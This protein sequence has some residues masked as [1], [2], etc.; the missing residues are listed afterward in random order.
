MDEHRQ[1]IA[2]VAMYATSPVDVAQYNLVMAKYETVLGPKSQSLRGQCFH[3]LLKYVAGMICFSCN[4]TWFRYVELGDDFSDPD[5]FKE[6]LRVRVSPTV[7]MDL[8][9]ACRPFSHAVMSL[10][11][12]LRDSVV[13]RNASASEENMDL[14]ADQANLCNW[15]HDQVAMHPFRSRAREDVNFNDDFSQERRLLGELQYQLNVMS[16]GEASGFPLMWQDPF[17]SSGSH[18]RLAAGLALVTL[19]V[20]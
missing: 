2:A 13:A 16:D 5:V 18:S 9:A 4:I 8:W 19:A 1:A 7:C 3:S 6:V 10:K 12:S 11:D 14:F 20:T 15:M 17:H